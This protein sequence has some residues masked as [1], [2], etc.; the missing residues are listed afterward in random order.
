MG[1]VVEE[2]GVGG[3]ATE[4]GVVADEDELVAGTGDGDV[5][6]TVDELAAG[7]YGLREDGE[8]P[9]G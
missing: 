7:L 2:G 3:K 5:Q 8:L 6:L 9:G 1:D 4:E